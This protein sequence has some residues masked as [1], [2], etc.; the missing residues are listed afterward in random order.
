MEIKE[1]MIWTFQCLLGKANF[2]HFHT[3]IKRLDY[4]ERHANHTSIVKKYKKDLIVCVDD[5]IIIEDDELQIEN[6]KEEIS[7]RI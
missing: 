1:R 6:P 3:V 4:K 7:V 2:A 5:I